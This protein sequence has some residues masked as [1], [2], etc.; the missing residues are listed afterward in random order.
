MPT[1]PGR[2]GPRAEVLLREDR[3]LLVAIISLGG[4]DGPAFDVASVDVS[5]ILRLPA[6]LRD[7]ADSIERDHAAVLE[8]VQK[9]K[10]K[11]N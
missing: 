9:Q 8:V 6:V 4:P 3:A 1:G 10:Q 2:Y 11:L 5:Q 7:V